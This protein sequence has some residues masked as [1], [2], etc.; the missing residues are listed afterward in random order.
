LKC[1]FRPSDWKN[2]LTFGGDTA[3]DTKKIRKIKIHKI[4]AATTNRTDTQAIE[5]NGKK[6][7]KRIKNISDF[8]S[9]FYFPQHCGSLF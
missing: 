3:S 2:C 6:R 4:A 7:K 1:L 8:G 9:L 5:N